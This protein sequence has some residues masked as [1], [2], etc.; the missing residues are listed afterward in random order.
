LKGRRLAAAAV[1]VALA[2]LPACA[3]KCKDGPPLSVN[4]EAWREQPRDEKG[5]WISELHAYAAREKVKRE[6]AKE[7]GVPFE[8]YIYFHSVTHG[9]ALSKKELA[10]YEAWQHKAR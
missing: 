5:R 9:P 1:L 10:D 4:Q 3:S 7:A 6:N 2:L 8:Q